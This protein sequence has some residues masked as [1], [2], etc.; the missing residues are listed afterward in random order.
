MSELEKR[1]PIGFIIFLAVVSLI[2]TVI[3]SYKAVTYTI[4]PFDFDENWKRISNID[5]PTYNQS[6]IQYVM[7]NFIM[8]IT[9]VIYAIILFIFFIQKSRLFP[10]ALVGFFMYRVLALTIMFYLQTVIKGPEPPALLEIIRDS[11]IAL[12]IPALW[13]PYILI[14]ETMRKRFNH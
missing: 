8:S 12:L 1:E 13:I 3:L 5:L 2:I 11:L 7:F 4:L 6:W 14:S 10:R 9:I